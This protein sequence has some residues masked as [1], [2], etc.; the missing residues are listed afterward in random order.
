[1]QYVPSIPPPNKELERE[2]EINGV[3]AT[4]AIKPVEPRTLPPLVTRRQRWFHPSVLPGAKEEPLKEQR[5]ME[6]RRKYCR[7][8]TQDPVLIDLRFPSDRRHKKHRQTD[9][10]TSVDEEV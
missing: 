2:V 5:V 9:L 8:L 7:R 6:E 1:M 10:S 4:K 3:S